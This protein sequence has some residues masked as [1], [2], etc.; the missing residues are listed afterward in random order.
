MQK[1]GVYIEGSK[2]IITNKRKRIGETE[3]GERIVFAECSGRNIAC[4]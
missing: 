1:E 4:M 3:K 2:K